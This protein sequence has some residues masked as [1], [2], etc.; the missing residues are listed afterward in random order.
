MGQEW[1]AISEDKKIIE[2]GKKVIV[3]NVTGI[4]LIVKEAE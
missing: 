4:K 3:L 2:I 1:S